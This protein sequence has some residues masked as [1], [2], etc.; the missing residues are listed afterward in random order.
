LIGTVL[1]KYEILQKIGDGGMATVYRGRHVTLGR[2]VAIKVMHPHLSA[3]PRNRQRFAREAR[4]IEHLDHDNI[5]KIFDY[6]GTDTDDCFI[7]TE[8]VDGLTLQ[9]L[10]AEHGALPSEIVAM[11]GIRLADALTYAHSLGIIHRDLKPENVMIRRDGTVKLMDFGIARFLDEI[12]LTMTGALVGS[13]AYMSPE[14]AMERVLDLRSDL[15]SMG[16]LLFHLVTGQLPFAGSNPSI[17]LRNIIE[18]KRPELMDLAPHASARLAD[19][20]ERTMATDPAGRPASAAEV[21]AG[22]VAALE[23][24]DIRD[25]DGPWRL[26]LWLA[27]HSGY[28]ARLKTHLSAAL[29]A[30]GRQRLAERDHL[31][32]LQLFNRLLC[33]DE[34]NTEV[35]ALI[36]GMHGD[37]TPAHRPRRWWVGVALLLVVSVVVSALLWPRA[38]ATTLTT[39]T[40][41]GDEDLTGPDVEA[42]V[43][44][45]AAPPLVQPAEPTLAVAVAAPVGDTPPEVPFNAPIVRKLVRPSASP[46]SQDVNLAAVVAAPSENAQI[47]VVVPDSWGYIYVDGEMKGRTGKVGAISVTPGVHTLRVENDYSMPWTERF[48]VHAGEAKDFQVTGLQ[49]KPVFVRLSTTLD[50]SCQ[51]AVDGRDQGTVDQVVRVLRLA[52]PD[53]PHEVR[54]TCPEGEPIVRQ[55]APTLPGAVLSLP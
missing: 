23:E 24:V 35:L 43:V 17:I 54:F 33:I 38:P 12:N 9:A 2:D 31:S 37:A 30:R 4:A 14:Q 44:D 19:L 27:D 50:G 8:F 1:D 29:L 20:V 36:Q 34:D 41:A 32:A 42:E 6:S 47:T 22:L 26:Q 3:S 53:K 13:P 11:L 51:V 16:T 18:G 55:V 28:E 10:V 49:R 5:L 21:R 25:G 48:E 40:P 52:E 45:D 39:A 7:V 46:N 15:F